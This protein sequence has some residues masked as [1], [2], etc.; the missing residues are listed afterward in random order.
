MNKSAI[1][2]LAL[3]ELQ[4]SKLQLNESELKKY[5]LSEEQAAR[6]HGWDFSHVYGR[7]TEETDLPWCYEQIIH[8]YR[9]PEHTLLDI[10]T[11][12]GEFLKV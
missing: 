2:E 11:G 6:I 5:R 4:A 7:Y 8:S 9:K 1:N 10:D 3:N 12:G